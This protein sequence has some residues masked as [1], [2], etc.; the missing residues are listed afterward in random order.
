MIVWKLINSKEKNAVNKTPELLLLL[1][2]IQTSPLPQ[3]K[4]G[5]R[6]LDLFA[7]PVPALNFH[8]HQI[9]RLWLESLNWKEPYVCDLWM[10]KPQ[11]SKWPILAE[12]SSNPFNHI[13][14]IY[15]VSRKNWAEKKASYIV[16][17]SVWC[18]PFPIKNKNIPHAWTY[19]LHWMIALKVLAHS[20]R[21]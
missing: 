3:L 21:A 17:A 9:N 15:L 8:P 1:W 11:T 2:L 16:T 6:I 10:L 19:I 7:I 14:L 13:G 5:L 18:C 4:I 12:L 20:V